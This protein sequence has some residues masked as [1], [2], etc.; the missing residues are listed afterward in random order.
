M[1]LEPTNY[2]YQP[3]TI[4]TP[5]IHFIQEVIAKTAVPSWLS[6]VPK[7]YGQSSAGSIKADEWRI[8]ATVYLPIALVLLWG[9]KMGPEGAHF[10]RILEHSM[11]LF[12]ATTIV[13]RYGA[14]LGRATTFRAFMKDWLDGLFQIHPHTESHAHRPNMHAAF[15]IYDFLLLFGPI[16]SWWCF[17]FERLIGI[18]QKIK[19]NDQIGGGFLFCHSFFRN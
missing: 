14:N 13:C 5:D 2:K 8:L 10:F 1:P 6:S 19:T 12:Q 9:D 11:A 4:S 16:I 15:H 3:K 7:D 18:L 17:P